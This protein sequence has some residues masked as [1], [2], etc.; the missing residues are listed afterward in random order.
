MSAPEARKLCPD[1]VVVQV[2][3]WGE[4][5][6]RDLG[7]AGTREAGGHSGLL[8]AI[9]AG[10]SRPSGAAAAFAPRRPAPPAPLS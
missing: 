2:G 6:C 1:L 8:Q 7:R 9:R 5:G 10:A 3:V 4:G